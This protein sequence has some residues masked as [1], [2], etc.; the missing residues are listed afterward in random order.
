MDSL[1]LHGDHQELAVVIVFLCF[2]IA[3]MFCVAG[4]YA[5]KYCFFPFRDCKRARHNK[6]KRVQ[7]NNI[8]NG[9]C[10]ITKR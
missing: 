9:V 10:T 6:A 8:I 5:Y 1:K 7:T 2:Q 4:L 3:L